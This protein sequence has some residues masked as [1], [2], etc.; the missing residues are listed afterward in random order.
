MTYV[1]AGLIALIVLHALGQRARLASLVELPPSDA[2]PSP[3]HRFG[4]APGVTLDDATRRAASA[5]ATREGLDVVDLVPAALPALRATGFAQL[6]DPA[7]IRRERFAPGRTFGHAM[8]V[9]TE[10]ADRA[11]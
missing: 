10:V 1:L 11:A 8:L 6:A 5:W 4:C 9:S 3:A 2:A 7:R